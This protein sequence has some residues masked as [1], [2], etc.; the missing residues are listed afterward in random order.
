VIFV[1]TKKVDNKFFFTLSFVALFGSGI[2]DE[3]K[4]GSGINILDLDAPLRVVKK[5]LKFRSRGQL[6]TVLSLL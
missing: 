1:A 5:T 3:Q 6:R 2:W 4:S